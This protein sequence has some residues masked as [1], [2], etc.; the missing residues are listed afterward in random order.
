MPADDAEALR[1]NLDSMLRTSPLR[2]CR[3]GFL[4]PYPKEGC[5]CALRSRAFSIV[6]NPPTS[7]ENIATTCEVA[8]CH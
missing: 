2:V 5:L 4:R 8:V 3:A 1:D 7:G 6:A